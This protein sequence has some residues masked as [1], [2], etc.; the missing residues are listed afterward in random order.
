FTLFGRAAVYLPHFLLA[1]QRLG[2][3]G[4]GRDRVPFLVESLTGEDGAM[5]YRR[6][7]GPRVG[8]PNPL[9][10]SLAPQ[11]RRRSVFSISFVTP[12]RIQVAGAVANR[13]GLRD[14]VTA[15]HRRIFLLS[16]FHQETP[17]D[18]DASLL[19]QAAEGARLVEAELHWDDHR[20]LSG[21][22]GR[23]IPIGGVTGTL[24]YEGDWGALAPLLRAGEYVHVGKNATFG[25]GRIRVSEGG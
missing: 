19:I 11:A 18:L 2:E 14:V 15:L 25:L 12:A 24:V 22:Q 5:L 20:R 6:C 10:L 23:Q 17:V 7:E 13:P 4:L 3:Q 8:R 9:W 16:S 1:L 21:R